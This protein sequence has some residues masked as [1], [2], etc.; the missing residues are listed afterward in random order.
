MPKNLLNG[1]QELT[2]LYDGRFA[3]NDKVADAIFY[4]DNIIISCTEIGLFAWQTN[5]D[6]IASLPVEKGEWRLSVNRNLTNIFAASNGKSFIVATLENGMLEAKFA[7]RFELKADDFAFHLIAEAQMLMLG[8][9]Y[10]YRVDLEK[11]KTSKQKIFS[12]VNQY[13]DF[14]LHTNGLAAM[15]REG[16]VEL[17]DFQE[18]KRVNIEKNFGEPSLREVGFANDSN[19]LIVAGSNSVFL[20]NLTT[21]QKG[22]KAWA[23]AVTPPFLVKD[24]LILNDGY[25]TI[26]CYNIESEQKLWQLKKNLRVTACNTSEDQ[27]LAIAGQRLTTIDLTDGKVG[28]QFAYEVAPSYLFVASNGRLSGFNNAVA[29][30]E[31]LGLAYVDGVRAQVNLLTGDVVGDCPET[32]TGR[33]ALTDTLLLVDQFKSLHAYSQESGEQ[34]WQIK[35]KKWAMAAADNG[36]AACWR[37]PGGSEIHMLNL[38]NG[39]IIE[40][41]K[42]DELGYQGVL[43]QKLGLL[44]VEDFADRFCFFEIEPT[45]NATAILQM[46]PKEIAAV[47]DTFFGFH[48]FFTDREFIFFSTEGKIFGVDVKNKQRR[49]IADF[50]EPIS[51]VCQGRDG[52]LYVA[53]STM[54]F[55]RITYAAQN[56]AAIE[57]TPLSKVQ[58]LKQHEINYLG[59][60]TELIAEL[61]AHPNVRLSKKSIYPPAEAKVLAKA[62]EIGF[63]DEDLAFFDQLDG[64][65]IRYELEGDQHEIKIDRLKDIVMRPVTEAYGADWGIDDIDNYD[66]KADFSLMNSS[67]LLFDNAANPERQTVLHV[68]TAGPITVNHFRIIGA[69]YTETGITFT[70]YLDLV[71]YS[72]GSW[73]FDAEAEWFEPLEEAFGNTFS[74]KE[75][76]IRKN[77]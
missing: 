31:D 41:V 24:Y 67:Y 27:L 14:Y 77:K 4:T 15:V 45:L 54:R 6:L 66:D 19:Q 48:A 55:Y 25:K 21:Q 12:K 36:L 1:H 75:L 59:A 2:E 30:H 35:K 50:D 63:S 13:D 28:H 56:L 42:T 58:S 64:C 17:Y 76:E 62:K 52:E 40:I 68:T 65:H 7:E 3:H 57:Y 74:Y 34:V 72:K 32:P 9:G 38:E 18:K 5:G 22:F 73:F 61:E 23:S 20:W 44:F 29:A 39:K 33:V 11:A 47:D 16:N 69:R 37:Q 71:L 51:A 46:S 43:S 10:L 70:K 60:V 26:D 53:A 8:G 49:L